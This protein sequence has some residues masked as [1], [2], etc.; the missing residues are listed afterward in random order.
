MEVEKPSHIK[1]VLRSFTPQEAEAILEESPNWRSLRQAYRDQFADVMSAGGWE[2]GNGETLAF[3]E[4]GKLVNGQ[5]RLSAALNFMLRC[6]VGKVWFWC[7]TGV[8]RKTQFSMDQGCQRKISA[9]LGAEGVKNI[10]QVSVILNGEAVIRHLKLEPGVFLPIV[11]GGIIPNA[12]SDGRQRRY[13]PTTGTLIDVWKRHRGHIV[14]WADIGARLSRAGVS[15]SATLA[16]VGFQ[17]AKRLETEAKLFFS[18]LEDGAG[19]KAGD[20]ILLLRDRMQNELRGVRKSSRENVLAV[21][22]KAWNAWLS[23]G[24]VGTLRYHGVGPKSESFPRALV[25]VPE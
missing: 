20:P 15:R 21:T 5:H 19:L 17:L 14:E 22:I 25:K 23:G 7:A 16:A 6:S 8:M 18:Y 11:N 12:G 1:F 13:A 2:W 24:Q 4:D 10:G 9:Y 3:D